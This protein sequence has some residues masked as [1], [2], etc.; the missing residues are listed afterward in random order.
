MKLEYLLTQLDK[1]NLSKGEYAITGSA[2]MAARGI[3]EAKDIDIVITKKLF[4]EL[5]NQYPSDQHLYNDT[6]HLGKIDAMANFTTP[7]LPS[8]DQQVATAEIIN[9][10]R[11]LNLEI[12]IKLKKYLG[13]EKDLADVK[14]I[15]N[16][17]QN[18]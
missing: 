7:N 17:L 18:I 11:V 15:D 10:Y 6:L 13:R 3:R 9:G 16:Y 1:L 5:K 14:L 12:L 2:A 4:Q 8:A